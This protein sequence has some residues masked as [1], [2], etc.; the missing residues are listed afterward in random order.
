MFNK[1]ILFHSF[2]LHWLG[3]TAVLNRFRLQTNICNHSDASDWFSCQVWNCSTHFLS[4][5]LSLDKVIGIVKLQI[6][7]K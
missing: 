4:V 2:L 3:R 6:L 5:E 1:L 7:F